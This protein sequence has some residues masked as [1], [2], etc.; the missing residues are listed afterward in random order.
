VGVGVVTGF[1]FALRF[2]IVAG[3]LTV[4]LLVNGISVRRL[5]R[6]SMIGV[7]LIVVLYVVR[8]APNYGGFSFYFSLHEIVSH[9]IGAGVVCAL[10]AAAILQARELRAGRGPAP[11]DRRAGRP[12]PADGAGRSEPARI[13]S[14]A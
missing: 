2:G 13:G 12:Q 4:I 14:G 9:W 10:I 3:P 8:P 5:V 7:L 6:L 1:V 11:R